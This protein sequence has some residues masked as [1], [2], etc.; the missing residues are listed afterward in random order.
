MEAGEREY[1]IVFKI[2]NHLIKREGILVVV[3]APRRQPGESELAFRNKLWR[4]RRLA[5][6]PSY[7]PEAE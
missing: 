2:I 4:E 3:A 1:E 5:L 6:S 7:V